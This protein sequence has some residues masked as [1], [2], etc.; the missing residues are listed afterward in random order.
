MN[1]AITG[2]FG[3]GVDILS[4]DVYLE[5]VPHEQFALLRREAPVYFHAEPGGRGFWAVTKH[6]DAHRVL[7]DADSFSSERGGTQ[8]ADLPREDMRVSPDHLANMD[9]PRH[10]RRRAIIGQAFTP[11]GLRRVQAWVH[12]H[13]STLIETLFDRLAAG[14]NVDLITDFAA[15]LPVATILHMVGV[16]DQDGPVMNRWVHELLTPDDVEYQTSE[17]QRAQTTR[18]F[19]EYAHAL[20]VERRHAPRDDLLSRLMAAEIDGHKLSYSEFGMFFLLLLAAGTHSTRLLIGNGMLAL[21]RHPQQRQK[22]LDNPALVPSAVEEFLRY[23]PP[24]QHFRRT[25]T[26]DTHVGGQRIAAGD[27]VAVFF[28]STNRDEDIFCDPDTLDVTRTP[29]DHLSFSHGPHFCL[30]NALAR[31]EARTAIGEC[32]RRLPEL[33]VAG[34]T[35]R[36]RSNW[37]NGVKQLPVK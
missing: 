34:P 5:G 31:M 6:R 2:D 15:Q 18:E 7:R 20:A 3:H 28:A 4:P 12:A 35:P 37:F 30:G 24:I 23:D 19:M 36:I 25:A 13:V 1:P 33:A 21:M 29:N 14:E 26:R 11:Q 17:A 10:T 27:K 9:P 8:I 16:P 32:V 22:L